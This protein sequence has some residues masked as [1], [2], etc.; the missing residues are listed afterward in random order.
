MMLKHGLHIGLILGALALSYLLPFELLVLSYAILGP[1]HY[2]TEIS[3]LHD[4]A[5]FMRD[6][7]WAY[8]LA[9]LT[10]LA[11]MMGAL[12]LAASAVF[13]AVIIGVWQTS[14]FSQHGTNLLAGAMFGGLALIWLHPDVTGL[15]AVLLPTI[16]HV[17]LFTFVFMVSGALRARSRAQGAIVLLYV[18]CLM[19]IIA[20]PPGDRTVIA[21]LAE[22]SQRNFGAIIPVLGRVLGQEGWSIDPRFGGLLSF[23]Y[24]YHYLNWFIKADIIHW[25]D[26]PK[27]RLATIAA[28][29][30][31]ATALYFYDYAL[32]FAVLLAISL[33]HVLLELPLNALSIKQLPALLRTLRA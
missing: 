21:P 32:G 8:G 25:A 7:G 3:W 30:F 12:P 28:F 9:L 27:K 2:M 11:L 6:K 14:H 5:Y 24:T 23:V 33:L 22:F 19:C 1:A 20:L 29:S 17:C 31:G 18:L 4:R 10:M 13:I 15:F 26:V 16:I